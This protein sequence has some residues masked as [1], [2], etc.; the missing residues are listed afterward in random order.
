MRK[1]FPILLMLLSLTSCG[2]VRTELS[3]NFQWD[4]NIKDYFPISEIVETDAK[5][6][7]KSKNGRL[8][9]EI[10]GHKNSIVLT[11][12]DMDNTDFGPLSDIYDGL[13]DGDLYRVVHYKELG[14]VIIFGNFNN[15]RFQNTIILGN[16][17][18][19]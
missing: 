12:S 2:V 19:K 16:N 14:I 15:S 18:K 5:F 3:Q 10:N 6:K 4:E 13:L 8:F 1:L 7:L 9:F 11:N 17:I